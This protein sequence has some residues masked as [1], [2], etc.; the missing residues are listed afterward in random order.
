[1]FEVLKKKRK[2]K[3]KNKK[4]QEKVLEDRKKERFPYRSAL[5]VKYVRYSLFRVNHHNKNKSEHEV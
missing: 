3:N 4:R 5:V 1:M 2:Q